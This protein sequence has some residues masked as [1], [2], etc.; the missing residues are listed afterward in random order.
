MCRGS[1]NYVNK[2]DVNKY[3]S[4]SDFISI[5]D[6]IDLNRLK[7][8]NFAGAAEP[9]LNPD[10]SSILDVCRENKII[11][12]FIT[13]GMLLTPQISKMI[14]GCSSK[15]HIS[16]GGS[17]KKT[18]E[19]IR[20]GADFELICEN[21]RHLSKLKKSNKNQ[22]PDIWLNPI[23]MKRNIH[24]LPEIIE[25]AKELG[26]QGVACS[27][28]ILDSNALIEESLFFHK[29]ECNAYLQ[30]AE[31]LASI[32]KISLIRPESFTL[33]SNTKEKTNENMEAWKKC[34]FLW[35]YAIL[36]ID[37]IMPCPSN[38]EIDFDGDIVRN[39][40]MD[41]WNNDWYANTRYGMLTGNPPDYCKTCKDP[42][43]KDVNDIGSY[44]TEDIIPEA[45]DY[46][47]SLTSIPLSKELEVS[48]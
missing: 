41:V 45:I 35:N 9:L 3:L 26:C 6:G 12:E 16:F 2:N 48:C 1:Q 47:Q 44:F 32:Y 28:L 17:N 5:L 14:L 24:E 11:V 30:K 40:F 29:Q 39:K 15:I 31:M 8:L 37:G 42:S 21:I 36:G 4:V 10:I 20:Q 19:A 23:L 27:H 34:R 33:E 38:E 25:L 7:I 22:Y 13:N 43:V 18:F 46:A